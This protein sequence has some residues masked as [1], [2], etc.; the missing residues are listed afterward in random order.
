MRES[1][2]CLLFSGSENDKYPVLIRSSA[3]QGEKCVVHASLRYEAKPSPFLLDHIGDEIVLITST[4]VSLAAENSVEDR[5]EGK[6][7]NHA[8]L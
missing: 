7:G 4:S 8:A 3:G 1:N 5:L 2:S 6:T